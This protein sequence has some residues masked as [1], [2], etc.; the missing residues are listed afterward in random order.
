MMENFGIET[1]AT[2]RMTIDANGNIGIGTTSPSVPLQ[3]NGS[4]S[5]SE[6]T[7][8]SYTYIRGDEHGTSSGGATNATGA[9][10]KKITGG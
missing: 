4:T 3:V 2:D 6:L 10:I 9:I 7:G 8:V 1:G 5:N